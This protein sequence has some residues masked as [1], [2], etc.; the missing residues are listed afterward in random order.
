MTLTGLWPTALPSVNTSTER[1]LATL[2]HGIP[3]PTKPV[4]RKHVSKSDRNGQL[5]ARYVTGDTLE[6][7]ASVYELSHQRVH[8]IVH[9]RSR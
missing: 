9:G 1:V 8:Q 7:L 4:T 2:Y 6:Q 5:R 3:L